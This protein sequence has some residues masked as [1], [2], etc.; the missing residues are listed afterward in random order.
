MAIN[1]FICGAV[2][3]IQT[4]AFADRPTPENFMGALSDTIKLRNV[5]LLGSHDAGTYGLDPDLGVSPDASSFIQEVGDIPLIGDIADHT[6][7]KSWAKTQSVD[8]TSQLYKGVRYFDLRFV[9]DSQEEFRI[10]HSLYGPLFDDIVSQFSNFLIQHPSEIVFLDF[11]HL[12]SQNGE[13]M[14]IEQQ[15]Q[16]IDK[17]QQS[18]GQKITPSNY[19]VDVTLGQMRQAHHQVIIFWENA[20]TAANFP[21]L[22][23]DRATFLSSI[24][25]NQTKWD[26]LETNLNKAIVT[27][28]T[29]QFYVNQAILTPNTTMIITHLCSDLLSVGTKT[30]IHVLEWYTKKASE[31]AAGN[32]LM[33]DDVTT[34]SEQAFQ[35]SWNYNELLN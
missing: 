24:W 31:G 6:V 9:V 11:Q 16:M 3:F 12:Y 1:K 21:T 14:A 15:C 19:G 35:I 33:I 4:L 32:I 34:A 27:Q 17:L 20:T 5:S 7:I 18:L 26:E 28:S 10:C 13:E 30:N 8:I 23:W 2:F 25:Y 22:L 29:E